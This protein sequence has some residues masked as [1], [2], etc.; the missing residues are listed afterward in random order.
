M[1]ALD[2]LALREEIEILMNGK[3]IID[4]RKKGAA[5]LK[6]WLSLI[7]LQI[8]GLATLPLGFVLVPYQ[9]IGI[10][11]G[12]TIS[13]KKLIKYDPFMTKE[14]LQNLMNVALRDE[15]KPFRLGNRSGK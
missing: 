14:R 2:C 5:G 11:I 13:V 9:A 10:E 12:K 6:S 4:T 3:E 8:V 1:I 15:G 7:G